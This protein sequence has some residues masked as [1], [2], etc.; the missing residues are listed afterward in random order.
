[1]AR[2]LAIDRKHGVRIEFVVKKCGT[3]SEYSRSLAVLCLRQASIST[4]LRAP[5]ALLA[6]S[7]ARTPFV[8]LCACCLLFAEAANDAPK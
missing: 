4:Q 5:S 3:V 7:D 2:E 1:M 6:A 8:A